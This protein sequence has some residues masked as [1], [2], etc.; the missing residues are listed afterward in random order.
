ML[1]HL[2]GLAI[3]P[4]LGRRSLLRALMN[5]LLSLRIQIAITKARL[6]R[7]TLVWLLTLI[8]GETTMGGLLVKLILMLNLRILLAITTFKVL[9]LG[10]RLL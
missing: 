9:L 1:P 5:T 6:N 10:G 3:L 8:D 2:H 7:R 4:Q